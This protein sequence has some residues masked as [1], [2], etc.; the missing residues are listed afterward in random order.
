MA[1]ITYSSVTTPKTSTTQTA[2]GTGVAGRISQ[3]TIG[4]NNYEIVDAAL[5]TAVNTD[6]GKIKDDLSSLNAAIP[7]IPVKDVTVN[8]TSVVNASGTAEVN[9]VT[10]VKVGTTSVLSNGVATIAEG[11]KTAKGVVQLSSTAGTSETTAATP[12]LVK[13]SVDGIATTLRGEMAEF[14]YYFGSVKST[15]EMNKMTTTGTKYSIASG[16]VTSGSGNALKVGAVVNVWKSTSSESDGMNYAW[17]GS[18][19]DAL[20]VSFSL[21]K[22][23]ASTLGGVKIG[24]GVEMGGTSTDTIA[25]KAYNGITVDSNGVGAKAGNGITVDTN[26]IHVKPATNGGITAGT[27]GVSVDSTVARTTAAYKAEF[28]ANSTATEPGT[29]KLTTLA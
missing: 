10:D 19:W 13:D 25:V 22:A 17:N 18:S 6:L 3:V 12:K 4:S 23:T 29:L 11:S 21:P 2:L 15:T 1:T 7:S 24:N 9:A 27:A 8:G 14:Y 20:G 26:G 16:V 28:V 5:R